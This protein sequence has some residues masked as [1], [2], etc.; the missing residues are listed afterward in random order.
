M[1]NADRKTTS[2]KLDLNRDQ[3]IQAEVGMDTAAFLRFLE[4]T[5][6]DAKERGHVHRYD[7][8]MINVWT[9]GYLGRANKEGK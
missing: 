3:I 9:A 6:A 7:V 1:I 4:Y 8:E 2:A 5:I